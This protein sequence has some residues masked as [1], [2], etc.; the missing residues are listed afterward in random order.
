MANILKNYSNIFL[1]SST[2]SYLPIFSHTGQLQCPLPKLSELLFS[3]RPWKTSSCYVLH[4]SEFPTSI[5]NNNDNNQL[6]YN[7]DLF[8]TMNPYNDT[9]SFSPHFTF[10]TLVNQIRT[11]LR[12]P[13]Q[14]GKRNIFKIFL[15]Y[16]SWEKIR[17]LSAKQF[18]EV[19]HCILHNILVNKFPAYG[20][21]CN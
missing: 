8:P 6:I 13:F 15:I 3:Y 9:F 10:L 18:I 12:V 2:L 14:R 17:Q 7:L 16:Y 19:L 20:L 11:R 21:V 5:H 4:K 1:T